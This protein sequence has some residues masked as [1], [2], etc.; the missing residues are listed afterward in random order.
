MCETFLNDCWSEIC[1]FSDVL[2]NFPS[3]FVI[4]GSKQSR[5]FK[6][7]S[8]EEFGTI[9]SHVF[10]DIRVHCGQYKGRL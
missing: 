2:V 10:P 8:L 1:V 7:G 9:Q 6:S 4:L 3:H 5:G